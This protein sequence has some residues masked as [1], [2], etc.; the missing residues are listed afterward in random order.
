MLAEID[1]TQ[2]NIKGIAAG[3]MGVIGAILLLPGLL[4]G[5]AH[6]VT[7]LPRVLRAVSGKLA[8]S[9]PATPVVLTDAGTP[10]TK[11][12][13]DQKPPEGFVEHL[14]V[15][16][17]AAPNAAPATQLQYAMKG[18]TEAEVALTEAK[19]ARHPDVA[20]APPLKADTNNGGAK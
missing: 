6:V 16:L 11:R 4:R 10:V 15:L 8:T 20:A 2:L 1:L 19:L 18:M 7:H 13:S 5:G 9:A 14:T 12:S 17:A 3:L